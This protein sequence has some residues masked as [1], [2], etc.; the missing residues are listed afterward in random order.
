MEKQVISQRTGDSRDNFPPMEKFPEMNRRMRS[1]HHTHRF[2]INMRSYVTQFLSIFKN[3]WISDSIYFRNAC[4]KKLM[5]KFW[6]SCAWHTTR[7]RLKLMWD[8]RLAY[9]RQKYAQSYS[10]NFTL[11]EIR[12]QDSWFLVQTLVQTLYV[13]D[14]LYHAS[15]VV[16]KRYYGMHAFLY[17]MDNFC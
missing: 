5:S 9:N 17:L 4:C 7:S 8:Y 16:G 14:Y 1:K 10:S 13:C 6:S 3:S 12:T 15:V 11:P 2:E